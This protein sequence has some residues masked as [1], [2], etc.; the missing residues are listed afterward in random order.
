MGVWLPEVTQPSGPMVTELQTELNN[1]RRAMRR[2]NNSNS[3]STKPKPVKLSSR[4]SWKQRRTKRMMSLMDPV[5][6]EQLVQLLRKH[7]MTRELF[8][9]QLSLS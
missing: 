2:L 1:L 8:A 4:H 7:S 3:S 5:R 6:A 9:R